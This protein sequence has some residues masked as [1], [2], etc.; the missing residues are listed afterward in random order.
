MHAFILE[1]TENKTQNIREIV[2]FFYYLIVRVTRVGHA[3]K[4]AGLFQCLC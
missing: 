2:D 4:R 1:F 3:D